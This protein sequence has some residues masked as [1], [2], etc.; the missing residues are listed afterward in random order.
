MFVKTKQDRKLRRCQGVPANS[1]AGLIKVI[2]DNQRDE[3][4]TPCTTPIHK[5]ST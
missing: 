1:F 2:G 3:S 4:P 5:T